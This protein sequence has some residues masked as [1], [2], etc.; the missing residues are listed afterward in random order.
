MGEMRRMRDLDSGADEALDAPETPAG[1]GANHRGGGRR[2]CTTGEGRGKRHRSME[3][4]RRR[5]ADNVRLHRL[6]QRQLSWLAN[7]LVYS[8]GM[9][10]TEEP[11][12]YWR[13]SKGLTDVFYNRSEI[14][15]PCIPNLDGKDEGGQAS[16]S[17]VSTRWISTA[18]LLQSDLT[19]LAQREGGE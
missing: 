16:S 2:G 12:K 4:F 8:S 11:I 1:I 13:E 9:G 17:A 19:T 3:G 14:V 15:Y 5:G 10:H 7:H 6:R 18:K